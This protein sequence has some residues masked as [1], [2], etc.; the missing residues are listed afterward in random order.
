MPQKGF[1]YRENGRRSDMYP[2]A[3][4]DHMKRPGRMRFG[5]WTSFMIRRLP[6]MLGDPSRKTYDGTG[7]LGD[8]G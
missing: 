7:C 1:N 6:G 3:G 2:L 8:A 4:V 5:R